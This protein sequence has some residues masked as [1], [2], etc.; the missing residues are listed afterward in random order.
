MHRSLPLGALAAILLAT[1]CTNPGPIQQGHGD[2]GDTI[3]NMACTD[4]LTDKD[5]Q[6]GYACVQVGASSGCLPEA[7]NGFC[8]GG[9]TLVIKPDN[10]GLETEV[11]LDADDKCAQGTFDC[12][13][14][15]AGTVCD[16][17]KLAC[18]PASTFNCN[19]C[20]AGT[21][22]DEADKTCKTNS[23]GGFDCSQCPAGTTCNTVT[24]SCDPVSTFNCSQCPANT[25]CD[26]ADQTCKPN[27]TN[28]GD[29]GSSGSGMCGTYAGP[30]VSGTQCQSC[31]PGGN[32]SNG[33]PCQANGCYGG[34]YCDTS[35]NRCHSPPSNCGSSGNGDGGSGFQCSQCP[36]N[37]TCDTV[38]QTCTPNS[39]GDGGTGDGGT[40]NP[41][42]GPVTGNV[43]DQGGTVSR[44]Y[45]AVV[46]DTRPANEWKSSSDESSYPYPSSI[47]STIYSDIT[48][49]SPQPSFVVA[50]GDYMYADPTTNEGAK[51][52]QLYHNAQQVYPGI[53]FHALGNH[54]C[55]GYTKS[56]CGS[57]N[58]DGVTNSFT[59]FMNAWVTPLGHSEPYYALS[60]AGQDGNWTAKIVLVAP[61]AWDS[62]QSSWLTTE[63]QK[64]TTFTFVVMHEPPSTTNCPNEQLAESIVRKYPLT[65]EING[66]THE[67]R[68]NTGSSGYGGSSSVFV[69]V[70]NGGAPLSGGSYGY[71]TVSQISDTQVVF[72]QFDYNAPNA[73]P[74]KTWTIDASGT[75]H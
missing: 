37:T 44:L 29:G 15:P 6:A 75:V 74:T 4:C 40:G 63:L 65:L 14:C 38:T 43:T 16:P 67:F 69:I 10:A 34:W 72:S 60:F 13:T 48:S 41:L 17:A 30:D 70:G 9:G 66:H 3:D 57:G 8:E 24:Q 51:Q 61:N 27:T 68:F 12:A 2:G 18:D 47:I 28:N 5:C 42:S 62:T 7:E 32:A 36:A 54:E 50:T 25:T 64:Q 33:Q 53:V 20:P 31:S 11:C 21:T 39:V 23:S 59:A 58:S 49:L 52:I 45:F 71:A 1:G 26:Q 35:D 56:N 19:Q 55:T 73:T 46:G 22:C